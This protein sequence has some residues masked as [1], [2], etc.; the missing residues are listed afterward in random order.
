MRSPGLCLA[1]LVLLLGACSPGAGAT[2]AP[3]TIAPATAAAASP[4][5]DVAE[6]SDEASPL[7]TE[8][9]GIADAL[10]A[11]KVDD[12]RSLAT[13][14][15]AGLQKLATKVGTIAPDAA[16]LLLAAVT[17]L[18]SAVKQFPQGSDL[19]DKARKDLDDGYNLARAKAC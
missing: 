7:A 1:G 6:L 2:V 3:A 19:V 14:A 5:L 8:L 17:D 16:P 13:S 12:A 18:E 10:K 9:Q 4:C 11:G 15:E